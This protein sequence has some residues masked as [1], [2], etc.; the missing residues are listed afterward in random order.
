LLAV[1]FRLLPS[2]NVRNLNAISVNYITCFIIG[3]LIIG[4]VPLRP[5]SIQSSWFSYALY[6][7]FCFIVF[8][9]I[10]AFSVQKVGMVITSIFQKLS[11]IFPVV[12]GVLIFGEALSIFSRIAIPLTVI[13]IVLTNLPDR[14][15]QYAVNAVKK[16]WYLPLLVI[17][18][19]GLIEVSLFYAQETD[20]LGQE[21]LHFTT[22]LFG[23]AG[24]WGFIMLALRR[25]LNF[26]L[27]ECIA[28][29]LIGIPNFFTIY[30]IVLGLELGWKGAVLFPVNNVGTI[31]FTSVIAILVFREKLSLLN[32]LGL[33]LALVAVLLFS[34]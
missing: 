34:F 30:L 33:A 2:Y 18:G 17:S 3:S 29:I 28:G 19:S 16:Y 25:R 13:A 11:L 24:I 9:N 4:E 14:S 31:F 20:R 27:N 26:N 1:L 15:A 6:L 10:N 8:F 22:S 5:S 23:M 12:A 21:G 32:Y 7:S